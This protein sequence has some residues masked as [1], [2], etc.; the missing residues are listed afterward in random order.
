[1]QSGPA[2]NL[3]ASSPRPR[4]KAIPLPH[5]VIVPLQVDPPTRTALRPHNPHQLEYRVARTANSRLERCEPIERVRSRCRVIVLRAMD[6]QCDLRALRFP[7]AS[8]LIVASALR[9]GD[10]DPRT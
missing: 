9:V 8:T 5:H 6:P 2:S 10:S 7:L 1:M 4:R 3:A